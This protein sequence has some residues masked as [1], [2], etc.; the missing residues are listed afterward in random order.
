M[1]IDLNELKRAAKQQQALALLRK[2]P[3][4]PSALKQEEIQSAAL[5]ALEKKGLLEKR[6]LEPSHDGDWAA[7]FEPGRGCASMASRRWPSPPLPAR[8][9]SSV[10]SCWMA[11]PA[12][13]KPRC[14]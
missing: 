5:T 2:G 6:S 12:P 3:Q 4:T 11:L 7:R 10:P 1:A 13:A 9:T 8:A 14:I